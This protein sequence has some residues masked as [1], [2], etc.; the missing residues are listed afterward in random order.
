MMQID[1]QC[2]FLVGSAMAVIGREQLRSGRP[3]AL[4]RGYMLALAFGAIVFTPLWI[5]ISLRW[6]AWESMYVWDLRTVPSGLMA[7]FP[8]ALSVAALAGFSATAALLSAGRAAFAAV[9]N[10][11]VIGSCIVVVLLGWDRFTFVGTQAEFASGKR[12][13]LLES[14]LLLF[15]VGVSIFFFAPAMFFLIRELRRA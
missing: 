11:A 1:L 5:Y 3:E 8:P 15:I 7:L 2:S 4:T 9:V 14:D 13:N 6:A 10:L 12:G